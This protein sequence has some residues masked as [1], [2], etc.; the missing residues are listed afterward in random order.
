MAEGAS[1]RE[2][3]DDHRERV[4]RKAEEPDRAEAPD[5][6]DDGGERRPER[7]APV[8][9]IEEQENPQER[10]GAAEDPPDLVRV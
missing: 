5:R 9:E 7:A 6:G 4:E 3:R 10:D 8:V 1:G 2:E